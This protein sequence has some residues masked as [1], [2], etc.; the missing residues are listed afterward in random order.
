MMRILI[1]NPNTSEATNKRIRS[2]AESLIPL[3]N[4][5]EVMSAP[6]GVSLIETIESS[7]ETVPAVLETIGRRHCEFDAIIIAAFSDPGL[8]EAREITNCPVFGISES[9]MRVAASKAERFAIVTLGATLAD[10]IC[11]N[12]EAYGFADRLSSIQVL[13]WTVEKVSA[14][15]RTYHTAFAESCERLVEEDGVGAVIIGGGPLSGIADE[16]ADRMTVPV[17]D[18]VRCAIQLAIESGGTQT[19]L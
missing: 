18:S 6:S 13:P 7:E 10:A 14:D 9:A 15:P 11:R 17:L 8:F 3:P 19:D 4:E 1:I 12:A 5:F 2:I 16:V